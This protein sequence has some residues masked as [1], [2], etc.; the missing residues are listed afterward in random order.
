MPFDSFFQHAVDAASKMRSKSFLRFAY[1]YIEH[2]K[3]VVSSALCVF[4]NAR[5]NCLFPYHAL[6]TQMQP[7]RQSQLF[8]CKHR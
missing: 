4:L 3:I 1:E 8:E 6:L 7:H 2:E 5:T